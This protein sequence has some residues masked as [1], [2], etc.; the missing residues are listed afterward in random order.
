MGAAGVTLAVGGRWRSAAA[1]EQQVRPAV[2]GGVRHAVYG[3]FNAGEL[4]AVG[5]GVT[6]DTAALQNAIDLCADGGGGI[7]FIPPGVYIITNTLTIRTGVTLEG[8]GVGALDIPLG[9]GRI[10]AAPWRNNAAARGPYPCGQT[11]NVYFLATEFRSVDK[12]PKF[13]RPSTVRFTD[14]GFFTPRY[15]FDSF[16]QMPQTDERDFVLKAPANQRVKLQNGEGKDA[17]AVTPGANVE[18]FGKEPL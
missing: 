4:G 11:N 5:N 7:V 14:A 8:A 10:I 18:L 2:Y 9:G 16:E 13:K 12:W 3:V 15:A 17:L 6:D 1:T